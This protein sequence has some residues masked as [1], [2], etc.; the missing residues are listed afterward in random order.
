MF[1]LHRA[2]YQKA[3]SHKEVLVKHLSAEIGR[4]YSNPHFQRMC[5]V[6]L[7]QYKSKDR[8]LNGKNGIFGKKREEVN[9]AIMQEAMRE[10]FL[11]AALCKGVVPLC[12]EM[13]VWKLSNSFAKP[14]STFW[15]EVYKENPRTLSTKR[16]WR[17]SIAV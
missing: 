4:V 12:V 1:T 10:Q 2:A 17:Q 15:T 14:R 9:E 6:G 11:F 8:V 13:T 16:L 7:K 3:P 5:H